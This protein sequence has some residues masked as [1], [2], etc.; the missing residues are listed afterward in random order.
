MDLLINSSG[1][2]G[3]CLVYL[4][5]MKRKDES[6]SDD[7]LLFWR[8]MWRILSFQHCGVRS[9]LRSQISVVCQ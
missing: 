4:N 3:T 7:A 1:L 2:K 9:A 6:C 8:E 5:K